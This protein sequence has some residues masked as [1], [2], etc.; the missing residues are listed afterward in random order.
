MGEYLVRG[1]NKIS[2]EISVSG[3]KNAILPILA[4]VILNKGESVIYNCPLISDTYVSIKI[5]NALGCT[6]KLEGNTLTINSKNANN[7]IVPE[8]LVREM[9]S[10]FIFLGGVLSRFG[11]VKISYPGGCELGARPIDLH[12][13]A[14]KALNATVKEEH[15]FIICEGTKL[16]GTRINLDFPSVGAT[17]NAMLTAVLAKGET[18][19]SNAAKEPEVVDLQFFLNAMGAK[20][21]GAGTDSITISGVSSLHDVEYKIMPDRIVAGTYLAAS[22]MTGGD[23][24]LHDVVYEDLYPI[25]SRL[26][27]AGCLFK[28]QRNSVSM[29]SPKKL[30]S[31]ERL[32]THPH[33]GF[34]TDMQPQFMSLLTIADGTSI[35]NETVFESRNKHIG[36]LIRMGADIILAQDGVT[37][38]IKGIE[39]LKGST[40]SARDLRGGAAL[41]LAGLV[42]EGETIVLN[43]SYVER[44]YECIE[45]SLASLGAD[46]TFKK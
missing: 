7:H 40:V 5:L 45:K 28:I 8:E 29:K 44:G 27:E 17:E 30:K 14:L 10:S 12:L 24:V 42:A 20:I 19:I 38:I 11:K 33:P 26:N 3:A 23:I 16:Q 31:I 9:R 18:I 15:G 1:G 21:K 6:T 34:P 36:E 32:R 25:L 37:S 39:K 41:I 13:K 22:A 2:G 46:I 35:V 43:S 4:S